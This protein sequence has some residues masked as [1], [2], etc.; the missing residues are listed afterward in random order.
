MRCRWRWHG[1]TK[2]ESRM[3]ALLH[4]TLAKVRRRARMGVLFDAFW[5]DAFCC[6]VISGMECG[7]TIGFGRGQVRFRATSA[8]PGVASCRKCRIT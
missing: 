7:S 3:T 4:A 5:D 6:A 2:D 8:F 1:R